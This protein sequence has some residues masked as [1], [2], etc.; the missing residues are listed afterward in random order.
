MSP[1]TR[2]GRSGNDAAAMRAVGFT[3]IELLVVVAVVAILA[4]LLLPAVAKSKTKT[5]GIACLSN[6]RQL[7]LARLL[8]SA[9]YHEILVA[10]PTLVMGWLGVNGG[11]SA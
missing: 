11:E 7:Q 10:F 5:H 2:G 4:G 8:Y 6:L 3:L 9:D 1:S